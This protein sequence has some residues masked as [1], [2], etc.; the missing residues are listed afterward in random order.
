MEFTWKINKRCCINVLG[1]EGIYLENI[2]EENERKALLKNYDDLLD[3]LDSVGIKFNLI[4]RDNAQKILQER[5]YYFK[6]SSYRKNFPKIDDKYNIDFA[7]LS[8]F[9]V[10]D[11]VLRYY[12]LQISLDVEHAIKTAVMHE[13]TCNPQIDGYDILDEFKSLYPELY[14]NTLNT[15]KTNEYLNDM[16]NRH[17]SHLPIWVF[18]EICGFG[19]L[20]KFID[21]YY[22]RFNKPKKL[23]IAKQ[24]CTFA[25]HIRNTSAHSNVFLINVYKRRNKITA[26]NF[27]KSYAKNVKF[28]LINLER[29]KLHDLFCMIYLHRTYCSTELRT[30]RRNYIKELSERINK[31]PEYYENYPRIRK[32]FTSVIKT[33]EIL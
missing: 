13:I 30:R 32:L 17:F 16:Y 21:Y 31:H 1:K 4:D 20:I 18:I 19:V 26:S 28:P 9:A 7:H 15:L 11:M 10:I 8:D 27:V 33:L 29:K 3:K 14:K 25:R 12:L 23:K 22:D 5:N 6:L 24:L 2:F